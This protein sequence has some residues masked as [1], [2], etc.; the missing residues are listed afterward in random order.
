ML[1]VRPEEFI[2]SKMI[3]EKP[4]I[5]LQCGTS[6]ILLIHAVHILA[7]SIVASIHIHISHYSFN[8]THD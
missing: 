4:V 3:K 8:C 2:G 5:Q 1:D 6:L 7:P